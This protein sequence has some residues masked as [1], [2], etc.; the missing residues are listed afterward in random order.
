VT[1]NEDEELELYK[2]L[3]RHGFVTDENSDE[4][5]NPIRTSIE[6][7]RA[8]KWNKMFLKWT[9]ILKKN[10]KKIRSRCEKG[11]PARVRGQAWKLLTKATTDQLN[12]RKLTDYKE[13]LIED[14]EHVTQISKD[15]N[16]TFPR[17]IL[18]MQ[19]GGQDSLFNVLKAMAIFKSE[20]G[21]C[22]GM[23]FVTALLL[24]YMEEED[25]F[26]VLV[27]LCRSYEMEELWKPGFPGLA[28]SFFILE[29]L[30][31]IYAPK[32]LEH[33]QQQ[34]LS[35]S[36]YATQWFLT[37]F[38]YNLDF[39]VA[40]RIW[41]V[42]L[43]EGFPFVYAVAVALLK[44]HEEKLM[45]AEFEDLF[46]LLQFKNNK[47]SSK[48]TTVDGEYLMKFANG[49]KEKMKRNILTFEKEYDEQFGK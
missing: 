43:Y 31:E 1:G 18:L 7:E 32:L 39:A 40:L 21:Y 48:I 27:Q 17:N 28:K 41:D 24:M 23:G 37:I 13:L 15:I 4:E 12:L 19:K 14:T 26:W 49:L 25:A 34:Q 2:H 3:N 6:M 11:I 29:K 9:D 5:I 44:I 10:N 36:V 38:L 16:R 33:L 8:L 42:F 45:T 47:V 46:A 20:L 30:L 35:T 22:Q